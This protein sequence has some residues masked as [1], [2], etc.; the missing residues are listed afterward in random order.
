MEQSILP[1][2]PY[3]LIKEDDWMFVASDKVLIDTVKVMGHSVINP[4]YEKYK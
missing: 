3:E 4:Q 2:T 1:K